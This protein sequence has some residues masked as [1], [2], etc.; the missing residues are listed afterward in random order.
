MEYWKVP[1]M[2]TG[3]C[4]IIGGGPSMSQQ[5]GIPSGIIS[6]VREGKL[7]YS[8]YGSYLTPLHSKNVIGTNIAFMLGEWVSALYFCDSKFFRIYKDSILAFR[9]LKV[10]CVSHLDTNLQPYTRNIKRVKRDYKSGLSDRPDTICWNHNSGAAAINLAVLAGAKRIL[11]LGFDMKSEGDNSHWHNAY[12][13]KTPRNAF[14]RFLKHFPAIAAD[15]KKM[16]V[17]ILNV[18]P[19]SLLDVFPRVSLKEVL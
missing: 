2:W 19:D 11:L 6:Q 8:T 4:W 13:I 18:C 12:G 7:P 3:D 16:K 10:T 15:A 17:E 1:Q 5:F 9:N 14:N